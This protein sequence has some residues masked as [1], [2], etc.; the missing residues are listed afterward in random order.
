M[1]LLQQI[2]LY[3]MHLLI[4]LVKQLVFI[5][6]QVHLVEHLE[7]RFLQQF[8]VQSQQMEILK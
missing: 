1:Q 6:W 4:K 8:M 5:K 3:Q 2:H 7:L